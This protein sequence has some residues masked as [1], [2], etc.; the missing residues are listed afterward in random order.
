MNIDIHVQLLLPLNSHLV[1]QSPVTLLKRYPDVMQKLVE[2][3]VSRK[4]D[5][6]LISHLKRFIAR[7]LAIYNANKHSLGQIDK[8]YCSPFNSKQVRLF[9]GL[10]KTGPANV[11][12]FNLLHG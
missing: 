11:C 6:L 12:D 4:E 3:K 1:V 8:M 5:Y 10:H 9:Q 2:F 7:K